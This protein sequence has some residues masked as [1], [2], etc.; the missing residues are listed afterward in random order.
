MA[1]AISHAVIALSLGTA[2]RRPQPPQRYWFI[3]V[4]CAVIPDIDVIGFHF[5]IHYGDLLGHRGLTHSLAFAA[6]LSLLVVGFVFQRD[7]ES[8]NTRVLLLYLFVA[9]AS[10]GVLD[11]MTNGGLG[12]AF[13][14]PFMRTRYFLPFRPIEV[15]PIEIGAFFTQRGV[16][17]LKSEALWIWVPSVCLATTVTLWRGR[18]GLRGS[19]SRGA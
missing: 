4:A 17:V 18:S 14:A 9:T 6:V 2:F 5:G 7:R 10:H 11:A 19:D 15:S 16:E 3:G 8:V 13:F 12:V 1:S